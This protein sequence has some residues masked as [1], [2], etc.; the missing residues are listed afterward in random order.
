MIGTKVGPYELIEELG[1]G[2]MATVYR[3]HQTSVDRSVAVKLIHQNFAD[4]DS[5][6]ARFTSEARLIA[7]LEHPHILPVYD[8][9]GS[10]TPPY[11]VM[12]YLPTGT[13]HDIMRQRI[14]PVGEILHLFRQ[15]GSAL[16]YAHRS[17]IV[18]RDIKPSNV[19]IDEEGNAFLTDFGIARMIEGGA[20]L[21]ATGAAI[22]TPG[23]MA[24]EQGMGKDIDG[25]IDIYAMGVILFEMLSGKLPFTADTPYAV[26]F[27]HIN[28]PV[29]LISDFNNELPPQL[30]AVLEQAMAK[31]P[32][33]RYQTAG[34]L[35]A[36]LSNS[37]DPS[38]NTKPIE[39]RAM[40]EQTMIELQEKRDRR[41]RELQAAQERAATVPPP[42]LNP[43]TTPLPIKASSSALDKN[44][45][46]VLSYGEMLE[47]GQLDG[48]VAER[49]PVPTTETRTPWALIAGGVVALVV[50]IGL[51]VFLFVGGDDGNGG[52]QEGGLAP[53]ETSTPL[54]TDTAEPEP[55]EAPA[56]T[57]VPAVDPTAVA[58]D[59]R[60]P[61]AT[62]TPSDTPSDTPDATA[63]D[64]VGPA[65]GGNGD[66][67]ETQTVNPSDTPDATVTNT[68]TE[69]PSDTPDAEATRATGRTQTAEGFTATPS[70]T[71]TATPSPT[72]TTTATSTDTPTPTATATSTDTPTPSTPIGQVP[73][74]TIALEVRLG[75]GAQ[76]P[77]VA[78]LRGGTSVEI[79]SITSDLQWV[80]IVY[81]DVSGEQASGFAIT[82]AVQALGGDVF[83]LPTPIVPT[84]TFTSTA[85]P[86]PTLTL[87]PTPTVTP[88]AT[89][90]PTLTATPTA[91]VTP[92]ASTTA[93]PSFTPAIPTPTEVAADIPD[94]PGALPFILDFE[95]ETDLEGSLYN[96]EDWYIESEGGNSALYGTSGLQTNLQILGE[97]VPE[98]VQSGNTDLVLRYDFNVFTAQTAA[99]VIFRFSQ[100]G[101]YVLEAR[102]GA[103]SLR[104]GGAGGQINRAAELQIGAFSGVNTSQW[105]RTTVWIEGGTIFVYL[106][107]NLVISV[108]DTNAP[109]QAG[110]I[111]LQTLAGAASNPAGY[112]NFRIQRAAL[113]STHVDTWSSFQSQLWT[114]NPS[115]NVTLSTANATSQYIRLE[116]VAETS[117]QLDFA[118]EDFF[119]A[120]SLRSFEGDFTIHLREG[121]LGA[122]RLAFRGGNLTLEVIDEFGTTL[123][124]PEVLPNFYSRDWNT[125]IMEIT[126]ERVQ[127]WNRNG[128]QV[129][130]RLFDNLP[131]AGGA[132][133]F[134][135]NDFDKL[136]IDDC[137]FA[138]S[139]ASGTDGAEFA[140]EIIDLMA[141]EVARPVRDLYDD[142]DD[143]FNDPQSQYLWTDD[144]GE[145]IVNEASPDPLHLRYYQLAA[146]ETEVVRQVDLSIDS[147]GTV[148]GDGRDPVAYTYTTDLYLTVDVMIPAD[149]PAGST[150]WLGMRSTINP[151]RTGLNHYLLELR[152]EADNTYTVRVRPDL[153]TDITPVY[154]GTVP[155]VVAGEWTNLMIIAVD[156]RM[157][158][159]VDGEFLA[160]IRPATGLLAGTAAIGVE[161]NSIANFDDF[162]LRDATVN[163]P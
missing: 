59:T 148:F 153:P 129:V 60:I 33:N 28:D 34:E 138:E 57:D 72:P 123:G 127:V 12:R 10:H 96:P 80:E 155:G 109:L 140:F 65:V 122:I 78:R 82:T 113:P 71:P 87:T 11:I 2:G 136:G 52:Q 83:A 102:A 3:A 13:L 121:S 92:T 85:T 128:V 131:P 157:A 46:G 40:A 159:F 108:S 105:Y 4:D 88:T 53:T 91:T 47:S 130:D 44:G 27:K 95:S 143:S 15:L 154:T 152:K 24:P 94:V 17:G 89:V 63:A 42:N 90:T 29:P 21:T 137:M 115:A 134:T 56:N 118:L 135:S 7:R 5:M 145:Y 141:N 73:P 81:V 25:R 101:Y 110:T 6:L 76:Y 38:V 70:D 117:P 106:N 32:N 37:I 107:E 98:W 58:E 67:D 35:V 86:T 104:R 139:V 116:G 120:C 66:T 16:D 1:R 54:P 99:R 142:H 9:N 144:P 151:S 19:M 97:E 156:D 147:R 26:I 14:L 43:K 22:G 64:V 79:V 41:N 133:F 158:F 162:I 84:E 8:F 112:D 51:A 36:D 48:Q 163:I 30:Q 74:Q 39:L 69:P 75:P 124:E 93:T 126:G 23:Y 149:A 103:L 45:D 77:V 18:H 125:F 111:H 150:A 119:F 68:A 114:Q 62:D 61:D 100:S 49:R 20:N 161:P 132:R 146:S 31:D 160:L 55:T 50:L